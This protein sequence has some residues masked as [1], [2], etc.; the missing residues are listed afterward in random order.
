M[1]T[2]S[3][4]AAQA[5]TST[6]PAT[7]ATPTSDDALSALTGA[8]SSFAQTLQASEDTSRNVMAGGGDTHSL[9]QS[10]AQSQLAVETVVTVRDKVVEAYQEILRMPV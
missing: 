3:L 10:L 4:M 6:R 7:A 2:Q 5:Y 8:A 1:D 9:V